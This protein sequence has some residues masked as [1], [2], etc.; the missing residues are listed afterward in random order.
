LEF[1]TPRV[2]SRDRIYFDLYADINAFKHLI[3]TT[4]LRRPRRA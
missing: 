1:P 4:L 3:R 2:T